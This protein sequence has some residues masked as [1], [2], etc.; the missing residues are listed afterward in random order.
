MDGWIEK[1]FLY[2]P[3]KKISSAR[4]KEVETSNFFEKVPNGDA[5]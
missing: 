3:I 2:S 4:R 5:I 1:C